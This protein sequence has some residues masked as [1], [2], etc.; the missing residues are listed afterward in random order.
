MNYRVRINVESFDVVPQIV[1]EYRGVSV[2]TIHVPKRIVTFTCESLTTAL[3][4]KRRFNHDKNRRKRN[5]R[6][7]VQH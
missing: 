1:R 5:P 6:G 2:W 3:K 7:N 4:I